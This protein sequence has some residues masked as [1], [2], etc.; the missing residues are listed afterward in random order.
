QPILRN[1]SDG[2]EHYL[3]AGGR[4][5]I[6]SQQ[7]VDGADAP[8]IFPESWV[9]EHLGS[10]RLYLHVTSIS[11]DSSAAWGIAPTDELS[12]PVILRSTVF[13]D[14]LRETQIYGQ[15]RGF[16]VRDTHW[17]AAWARAGNL[18][19]KNTFDVPVAVTVPQ[20]GGGRMI[21]FSFPIR[22]ANG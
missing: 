17:V 2:L 8:G 14:S 4:F 12:N 21:A 11:G 6:E 7:L 9:S 20:P 5:M 3:A 16:A 15:L 18:T 19:E 13:A 22:T 1:Y 10:D